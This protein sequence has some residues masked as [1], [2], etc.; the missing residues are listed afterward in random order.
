MENVVKND[1]K[2]LNEFIMFLKKNGYEIR[3]SN[4]NHVPGQGYSPAPYY[5]DVDIDYALKK[6]NKNNK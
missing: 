6:F 3:M 5:S 2:S 1:E 4:P